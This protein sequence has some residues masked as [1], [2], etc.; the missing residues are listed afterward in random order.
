MTVREIRYQ[1]GWSQRKFAEYFGIP[2]VN[3]QH[4]EQGVAKPPAYVVQMLERIVK[5]E[6]AQG[7][8]PGGC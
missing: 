7:I 3:V 1:L 6:M 4:W 5:L 8:I 2:V